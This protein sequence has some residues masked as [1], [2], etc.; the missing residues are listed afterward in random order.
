MPCDCI[1]VDPGVLRV[2]RVAVDAASVVEA[3]AAS[4]AGG[5]PAG[6]A[7][8]P[9]QPQRRGQACQDE[10]RRV[11]GIR[12]RDGIDRVADEGCQHV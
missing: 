1:Q 6:G 11:D 5:L 9:L 2:S 3:P 12:A 7:V 4:H 8:G 10:V